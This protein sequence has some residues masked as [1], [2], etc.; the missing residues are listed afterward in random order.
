MPY[1]VRSR[2]PVVFL[3]LSLIAL[4]AVAGGQ[5][6]HIPRDQGFLASL[7]QALAALVPRVAQLGPGPGLD[8][9]GVGDHKTSASQ[10]DLGPSLDPLG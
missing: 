3:I 7:W 5:G 4:P 8:P 2:A 6:A 1:A 10:G 9:V